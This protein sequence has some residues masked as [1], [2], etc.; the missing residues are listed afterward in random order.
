MEEKDNHR[1][2]TRTA[3]ANDGPKREE[4]DDKFEGYKIKREKKKQQNKPKEW[5]ASK[6]QK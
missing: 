5:Y 4:E 3:W 6:W 2:Q 1:N